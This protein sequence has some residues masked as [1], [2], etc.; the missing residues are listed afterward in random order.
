MA[1]PMSLPRVVAALALSTSLLL[2]GVAPAL[3][4]PSTSPGGVRA[5]A[6]SFH[7]EDTCIRYGLVSVACW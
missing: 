6:S 5:A 7:S 1:E 2:S 3:A 4:Q